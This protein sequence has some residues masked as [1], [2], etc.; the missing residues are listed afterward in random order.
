M[1]KKNFT[2]SHQ[3]EKSPLPPQSQPLKK[4]QFFQGSLR[5]QYGHDTD[6]VSL[7]FPNKA[8]NEPRFTPDHPCLIVKLLD[9][10][11]EQ[12]VLEDAWNSRRYLA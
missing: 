12:G 9:I 7:K 4:L 1:L 8:Q 2:R 11:H 3:Q 10:F 6:S 5:L